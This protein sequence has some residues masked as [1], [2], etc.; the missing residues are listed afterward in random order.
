MRSSRF[1]F[2]ISLSTKRSRGA[3][4]F[5]I[6]GDFFSP[7][8]FFTN[9]FIVQFFFQPVSPVKSIS[10]FFLKVK[11]NKK[12]EDR[13]TV[14]ERNTTKSYSNMCCG[15]CCCKKTNKKRKQNKNQKQPVGVSE[16]EGVLSELCYPCDRLLCD[17][18][19]DGGRGLR[20]VTRDQRSRVSGCGVT[21]DPFPSDPSTFF[22]SPSRKTWRGGQSL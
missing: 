3:K 22:F 9:W 13:A 17:H 21:R 19:G 12:R 10:I 7:F 20:P 14:S 1:F 8:F 11:N 18:D 6:G 4:L 15:Y 16:S 2:F 5:H